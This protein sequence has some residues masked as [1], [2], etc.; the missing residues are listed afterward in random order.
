MCRK[1]LSRCNYLSKHAKVF[2][3]IS[4]IY[5]T[6]LIELIKDLSWRV[7]HYNVSEEQARYSTCNAEGTALQEHFFK[8]TSSRT[9]L[10]EHFFRNTSSRTVLHQYWSQDFRIRLLNCFLD[11]NST[12]WRGSGPFHKNCLFKEN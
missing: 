12:S 5:K 2:F 10:Q 1:A 4:H 8:N 6:V 7:T 11:T 9:L 3:T